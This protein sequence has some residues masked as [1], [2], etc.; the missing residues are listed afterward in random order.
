MLMCESEC[1][2]ANNHHPRSIQQRERGSSEKKEEKKH[3]NIAGYA[4]KVF[5]II[6]LLHRCRSLLFEK[7][8]IKY[9]R[10]EKSENI[11]FYK[12]SLRAA[13]ESKRVREKFL[14]EL[15]FK[16]DLLKY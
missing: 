13:H 3:R 5:R 12:N 1:F 16:H 8:K 6:S 14:T 9:T 7:E 15:D 10:R 2:N 11:P 4:L